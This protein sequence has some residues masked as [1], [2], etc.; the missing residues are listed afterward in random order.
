MPQNSGKMR[1][2]VNYCHFLFF[3]LTFQLYQK[4]EGKLNRLGAV[5]NS[6]NKST[7]HEVVSLELQY[8]SDLDNTALSDT[9]SEQV[10]Q[11]HCKYLLTF[12]YIDTKER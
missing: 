8:Q 7:L 6:E 2:H 9:P 3:P 5:W 12:I 1:T 4:E 11:C 10:K